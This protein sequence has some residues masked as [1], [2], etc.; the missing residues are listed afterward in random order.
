MSSPRPNASRATVPRAGANNPDVVVVGAGIA[1]ASVAAVLARGGI[2]VLLLE[3]QL[4]YRDRVR[5]E[6]MAPWG[7]LEARALGLESVIR[8]TQAVDARYMVPFDELVDSSLA[9]ESARDN[10]TF[11]PD[12][13]GS[14]CASHPKSCHALAE[15]AV[16]AGAQLVRGVAEVH[17]RTGNR[18]TITFHNGTQTN[19]RPRL[20][21][22]ADGRT[23][24]VRK[25][26]GIQM[27]A[28][29]PT[30][31][32]AGLLV[33]GASRWP[34]DL[35]TVGV[36]GDLQ[37]Y[38]F[39]QGNGRLRL[40]TC[41]AN[42]QATRW[43]GA[44][45]AK[46][47][48]EA[49]AGLGAI[50]NELG[51]GEVMPAGP[52]ATFSSEHTWCDKPYAD[53]VVLIGDAG[54]YDDPVDGQGLSLALS[55]VRQLGELLLASDDWTATNLSAYGQR[56]AGRLRRMRRVS[57]TFATLMTTFTAAGRARRARYYAASR[58]GRDDVKTA[59]VPMFIGPDRPPAE[60]FTDE[61]H[62]ALLTELG[63]LP[64][65][66]S[67]PDE[68]AHSAPAFASQPA[69]AHATAP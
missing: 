65:A 55:D 8:S 25:Q 62:E 18:P 10:S 7:V 38:V 64:S 12:V 69:P 33:E 50:P 61:L 3:R 20:I 48:V 58:A 32:I 24:T 66:R 41:H 9:A 2:E 53:G 5:G 15:E 13:A 6:Y 31:L 22:G 19:L 27:N 1:G 36:E 28:A 42:E 35:Y 52:C 57:K 45:G 17:V 29:P 11:L 34:E 59:L 4:N 60:A 54:G 16:R 44:S 49:F 21:I 56:R 14:L 67:A 68:P 40:Y 26:S 43:A 63:G 23:S 46:R 37:F 30:H 47:F 51:L 39:P